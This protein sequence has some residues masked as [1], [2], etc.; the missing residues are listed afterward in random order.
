MKHV[1]AFTGYRTIGKTT[2]VNT[3]AKHLDFSQNKIIKLS[4]ADL[5]RD[6]IQ[7]KYGT[8]I[9]NDTRNY[10]N[11]TV[12]KLP[13]LKDK[14]MQFDF[15]NRDLMIKTGDYLR[16]LD[17]DIFAKNV[18]DTIKYTFSFGA[19]NMNYIY[20]IDDLRFENELNKLKELESYINPYD[21]SD[22]I[23]VH[24]VYLTS[25]RVAD[26][27]SSD[28]EAKDYIE[29]TKCDYTLALRHFDNTQ[30]YITDIENFLK[31]LK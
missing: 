13:I 11:K 29:P 7:E 2:T 30:E 28:I 4:F 1:I 5:L 20:L 24:I 18:C 15:T 25:P 23:K 16:S 10:K 26:I 27:L 21:L 3:I 19:N 9:A 8:S 17:K 12:N 14:K 31:I 6:W 22:K